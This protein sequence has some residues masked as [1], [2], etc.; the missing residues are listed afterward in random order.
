MVVKKSPISS[1]PSG[2]GQV[3]LPSQAALQQA[4]KLLGQNHHR[5]L[6]G[7]WKSVRL[8][9]QQTTTAFW[10]FQTHLDQLSGNMNI[11]MNMYEWFN[12]SSF[13]GPFL[14]FDICLQDYIARRCALTEL[15]L[16]F[17]LL[18]CQ[19]SSSSLQRWS[20]NVAKQLSKFSRMTSP[21]SSTQKLSRHVWDQ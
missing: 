1:S 14:T 12:W 16:Q 18:G 13:Q 9:R 11:Y 5:S 6:N 10:L 17:W 7:S 20:R 19:L 15:E 2:E 8:C 3:Q 21:C 4:T